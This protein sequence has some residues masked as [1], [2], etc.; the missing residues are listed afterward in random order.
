MIEKIK[1][2]PTRV[3]SLNK[4]SWVY[5]CTEILRLPQITHPA[6]ICGTIAHLALELLQKR[7][8]FKTYKNLVKRSSIFGTSIE[9]LCAKHL[10]KENI[11]SVENV[12]KLDN[13]IITGCKSDFF[14]EGAKKVI[15]EEKITIEQD[16]FILTSKIDKIALYEKDDAIH[17]IK[18]WDYKSS[19]QKFAGAELDS[20]L[21]AGTYSLAIW[22]KYKIIPELSFV[23][24]K[25][26]QKP[27][28]AVKKFTHDQLMDI[29]STYKKIAEH[30]RHF[31]HA[32]AVSNMAAQSESYRWLCGSLQP[33]KFCCAFRKPFNYFALVD[34][35]GKVLRSSFEKGKLKPQEGCTII[36]RTYAGCPH[37]LGQAETDL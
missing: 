36:A 32:K 24:L 17:Q 5:Y 27:F 25:F 22:W 14:P 4:C 15:T 13:F 11:Y 21:Q 35:E 9:F 18:V 20:N 31:D 28:Q 30:V 23:F 19:K 2:S 3:Q 1:L 12:T 7:K 33:G 8:H 29:L 34:E 37:W 6:A 16:D 26:N 10:Y